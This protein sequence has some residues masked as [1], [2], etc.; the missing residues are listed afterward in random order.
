MKRFNQFG[1]KHVQTLMELVYRSALLCSEWK[2]AFEGVDTASGLLKLSS[3]ALLG[4]SLDKNLDDWSRSLPQTCA[5]SVEPASTESDPEWL[6]LLLAGRGV[7]RH[8]HNYPSLETQMVWRFYWETRMILS[9]VLLY[10]NAVLE[11]EL[12]PSNPVRNSS[13]EVEFSLLYFADRLCESC[14]TPL[15]AARRKGTFDLNIEDVPCLQ[16]YLLL[17]I[18][19]TV[20]LCLHQVVL[21][22]V[23]LSSRREWVDRMSRFVKNH[24]GFAKTSAE[25]HPEQFAILPIQIWPLLK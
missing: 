15:A 25:V 11:K 22:G 20:G 9:Q 16:G 8:S 6:G 24:F 10:T 1:P 2:P 14:I 13:K 3:I 23:D 12:A 17:H 5:Y 7:P 21:D 18:L 4:V 19:P